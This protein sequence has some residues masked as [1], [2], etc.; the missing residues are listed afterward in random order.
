M[1]KLDNKARKYLEEYNAALAG[2]SS[3]DECQIWD[4]FEKYCSSKALNPDDLFEA[5][6]NENSPNISP[7]I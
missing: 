7:P 6:E 1:D 5:F 4:E 2:A 3:K